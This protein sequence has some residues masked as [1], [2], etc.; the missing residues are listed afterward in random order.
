[1]VVDIPIRL[2][3]DEDSPANVVVEMSGTIVWRSCGGFF[4]GVTFRRSKSS[5]GRSSRDMLRVESTGKMNIMHSVLDNEGSTGNVVSLVGPGNKGRWEFVSVKNGAVGI[6]MQHGSRLE[7]LKV[8]RASLVGLDF[9][10][11][12]HKLS[13]QCLFSF[14]A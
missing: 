2:I 14:R 13:H 11:R 4:E 5:G 6:S 8:C 3:G 7:L 10:G 9:G 1:M 12:L